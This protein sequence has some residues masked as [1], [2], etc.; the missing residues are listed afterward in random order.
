M[1]SDAYGPMIERI[2]TI[3]DGA[4]AVINHACFEPLAPA[5]VASRFSAPVTE[6]VTFYLA[7]STSSEDKTKF[8]DTVMDFGKVFQQHAKGFRGM[9]TGWIVEEVEHPSV[10][11]GIGYAIAVGWDSVEAHNAF[12]ETQESKDAMG[13]LGSSWKGAQMHHVKFQEV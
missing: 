9:S 10:G 12:T 4:G 13:R 11:T 1:A 7:S 8:H 2:M 5:T 3:V 6:F